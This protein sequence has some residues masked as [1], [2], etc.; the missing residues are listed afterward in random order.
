[1]LQEAFSP[2]SST[3]NSNEPEAFSPERGTSTNNTEPYHDSPTGDSPSLAS[4]STGQPVG[5]IV[6]VVI[7]VI[8][9]VAAAIFGIFYCRR[10]K[11]TRKITAGLEGRH[12]HDQERPRQSPK[13]N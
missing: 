2:E 5:L 12:F 1:M 10:R 11:R 3:S 13:G 4:R 6:G 7:A 9:L 8:I